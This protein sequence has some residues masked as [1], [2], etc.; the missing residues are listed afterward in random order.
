MKKK[1]FIAS[2]LLACSV[3]ACCSCSKEKVDTK[4]NVSYENES[5]SSNKGQTLTAGDVYEF[6]L[7]NQQ[8]AISKTILTK[9]MKSKVNL[10]DPQ[11][12]ALY[13]KYLNDYFNETFVNSDT[14][15]YDGKFSE[16]LLVK[17]LE[18][19]SYIVKCGQGFNSGNLDNQ[20][21]KC[22]YTD[23]I[24]KE[25][26][27]DILMK[28]LKIQY[29][30][31]EKADLI[32][33]NEARRITYYS[34]SKGSDD[35]ETRELLET[36]VASIELNHDSTDDTLVKNIEDVALK[37]RKKDLDKIAEEYAYISTSTDS[38]SSFT[39]LNK[40]TTCG[41]KR[42]TIEEGKAYQ[43]NLIMEKEYYKTE[44]VIKNNESILYE[45]A[46]NVLFSE[47]V[48]DYLYEIGDKNYLMS[49]AYSS[50]NDKRINDIIL[51]D[52]NTYYLAT[53]DVINSQSSFEDKALVAELLLDKITESAVFDYC[54]KDQEVEVYDKIIREYF[55]EK[56]GETK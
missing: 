47:N 29:L 1:N 24:E 15:K 21:F 50:Q 35:N 19:E 51:Y 2:C 14:Y 8:D 45:A 13:K 48:N 44:V 26:D 30:I 23:Y 32:D 11:A 12:L 55:E 46:R 9:I 4:A 33:K 54:Y 40:F 7:D 6:I 28:I 41:N 37:N 56:Y 20:V 49:P 25:V 34:V 39:Y 38:G 22:D 52:S 16:E 3:L 27:Y 5:I 53:V 36:Y 17:Y 10:S 31:N 18:S 43:D 42:C